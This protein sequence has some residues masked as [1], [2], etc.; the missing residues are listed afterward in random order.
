VSVLL[1]FNIALQTIA[2][3]V[4]FV[5]G[6]AVLFGSLSIC[7]AVALGLYEGAKRIWAYSARSVFARRSKRLA[8]PA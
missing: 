1:V 7:F 8:F 6:Y 4:I 5:V 3:F 2:A